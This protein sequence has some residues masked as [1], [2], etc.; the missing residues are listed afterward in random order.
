MGVT[1]TL[2]ASRCLI[3]LSLGFWFVVSS[4]VADEGCLET[5]YELGQG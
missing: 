3:F 2:H 1:S 5:A 4:V